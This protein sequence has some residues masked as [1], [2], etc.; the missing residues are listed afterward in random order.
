MIL[1]I[2]DDRDAAY[3][4]ACALRCHHLG[5]ELTVARTPAEALSRA[6]D[7]TEVIILDLQLDPERGPEGGLSL[8]RELIVA[9]P[10]ARAIVLTGHSSQDFGVRALALGAASFLKK[11]A[12]VP[13]LAALVR[14]GLAQARLKREHRVLLNRHR[15]GADSPVVGESAAICE[16][17]AQLHA[18]AST[19]QPVLL[20][21]ETGTGK[22]VCAR[23]IHRLSA[24][25]DAPFIRYQPLGA[26]AELAASDLF[27][28]AR[29]AFTGATGAR[30]GMIEEASGGTLFLDEIDEYPATVQVALLGVLQDKT[31]RPIGANGERRCDF[32]LITASNALF[33]ES[34]TSGKFRSDLYHRIAAHVIELPPLRKRLEDLPALTSRLL[35]E[36]HSYEPHLPSEIDDLA[37]RRLSARSWP[38]NVRELHLVLERA[39]LH[40]H[41]QNRAIILP[42]DIP[43]ELQRRTAWPQTF[44]E[45]VEQY[46]ASL[47]KA[48][49]NAHEGNQARAATS[50]GLDRSTLRRIL[51]RGAGRGST[52]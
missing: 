40:A 38:G 32:R 15:Y 18:A 1:L 8:L 21:G 31:V 46:E 50:L 6:H 3:A 23:E 13:H 2:D 16:V 34:L 14:D 22:G 27:G 39:A 10:C 20:L 9:A 26:S 4:L 33:P 29:G 48:A 19:R 28:H 52:P 12:D 47:V 41:A 25:C 30:R 5:A 7:N 51:K 11:P 44:R 37:L 43:D 35:G 49:L 24:R 17:R 36:L 45:Q 42:H